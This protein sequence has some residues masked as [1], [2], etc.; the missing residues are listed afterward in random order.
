MREMEVILLDS[1]LLKDMKIIYTDNRPEESCTAGVR[2]K[3][4]R[5]KLLIDKEPFLRHK[6]E[7]QTLREF[8]DFAIKEK[9]ILHGRYG[10]G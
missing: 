5:R 1:M 8:F 4:L 9:V 10:I 2:M 6:Y 7:S 3:I